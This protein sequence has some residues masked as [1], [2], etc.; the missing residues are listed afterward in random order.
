MDVRNL[1]KKGGDSDAIDSNKGDA[2]HG[3]IV[4]SE[5]FSVAKD[6]PSRL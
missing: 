1:G 6:L 5:H 4:P 2:W 3:A